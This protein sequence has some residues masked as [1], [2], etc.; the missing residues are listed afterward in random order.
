[1]SD[2]TEREIKDTYTVNP[3]YQRRLAQIQDEHD[4]CAEHRLPMLD[5]DKVVQDL[6]TAASN[7][8]IAA[9][10]LLRDAITAAPAEV[11]LTNIVRHMADLKNA[12]QGAACA[13][14]I[15]LGEQTKGSRA[16]TPREGK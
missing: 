9:L 15:L 2:G 7:A 4:L 16:T 8:H 5:R 14:E 12:V 13:L 6:I 10:K 11:D 3:E 1:M